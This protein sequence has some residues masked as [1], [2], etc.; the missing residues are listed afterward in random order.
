MN[1]AL[2]DSPFEFYRRLFEAAGTL[3]VEVVFLA[4]AEVAGVRMTLSKRT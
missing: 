4:S 2:V 3:S 1:N